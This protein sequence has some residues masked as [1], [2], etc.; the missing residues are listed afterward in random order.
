MLR[1]DQQYFQVESG[2]VWNGGNLIS[3]KHGLDLRDLDACLFNEFEER[4][5]FNAWWFC[6]FPVHVV[7]DDNLP[8]PIFIRGDDV[9]YGLRNM[10]YLI[11]MNGIC[12]W[13]EAFENKYSSFLYYYILRNRLIDNALHN[14]ILPKKEFISILYTQ[15]MDE[16]RLYRYRNANLIMR[17][18]EDFFRGVEWLKEQDGEELHKEVMSQGYKLQYIEDLEDGI[19]FS[20]PLYEASLTAYSDSG[21][22]AR[23]INHFTVNGTYL[24]PTRSYNIVP[25]IAVQQSSVYRTETILNYDYSSKKG[26]VTHRSPEEAK[27]CVKRLKRLNHLIEKEYDKATADFAV[28]VGEITNMEFWKKYLQIS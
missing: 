17:G 20:Y 1:M 16:I 26:F 28:Q 21:L 7:R 5:Q 10:K 12:V 18:V 4:P 8:L 15:V 25:T 6:A 22:K 11:L 27:K 2:A 14:M 23:I 9:E 24:K 13:H 3:L 19:Q